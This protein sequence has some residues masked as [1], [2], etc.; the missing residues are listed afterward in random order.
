M[1]INLMGQNKSLHQTTGA[2]QVVRA[3]DRL[4]SREA[5]NTLANLIPLEIVPQATPS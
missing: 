4:M 1:H 3:A 2:D 5:R